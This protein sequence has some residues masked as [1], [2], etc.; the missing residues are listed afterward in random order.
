M[1]GLKKFANR[2][3]KGTFEVLTD[4][5]VA[6]EKDI[7]DMEIILGNLQDQARDPSNSSHGDHEKIT[8][9]ENEISK[10]KLELAEVKARIK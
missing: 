4:K 6:L 3:M 7:K 9:W 1:E 10:R 5:K 2:Y 8:H